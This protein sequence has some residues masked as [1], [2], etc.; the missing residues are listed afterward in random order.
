MRSRPL[1]PTLAL[2]VLLTGPAR[3]G[4]LAPFAPPEVTYAATPDPLPLVHVPSDRQRPYVL[5]RDP[6]LG[7]L[8]FFLDT[9]FSRTTCDDGFV[10]SLG[11]DARRTL[12]RSRGEVGRVP[13]GVVDIPELVLGGHV[14]EDLHCAVRDLATTSSVPQDPRAPV[15]GVLGSDVMRLFVVEIDP[16]RGLVTLHDPSMARLD[17]GAVRLRRDRPCGRR[18]RAP[19]EV[20]GR[21]TW[22]VIDTGATRTHLDAAR[23]D[24]PI[25][26]EREG[27]LRGSG[28]GGRVRVRVREA[29]APE[30]SLA[31]QALGA[32][33]FRD[34]PKP[35]WTPGLVGQDVLGRFVLVIDGPRR[36][37]EVRPVERRAWPVWQGLDPPVAP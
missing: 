29:E 31:G 6:A 20:A 14:L 17:D 25:I 21:T 13:L 2:S 32:L 10:A 15:A 18:F 37:L 7:T 1:I 36:R 5:V 12:A 35:R 9:G 19:L 30:A 26:W 23:L 22:P 33:R 3:S 24:L 11:L 34:R 4:I 8:A 16:G 28:P 27:V